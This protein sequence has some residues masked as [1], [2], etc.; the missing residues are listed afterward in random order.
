MMGRNVSIHFNLIEVQENHSN[1]L[2]ADGM[3]VWG[4]VACT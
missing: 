4:L 1:R 2:H 3:K